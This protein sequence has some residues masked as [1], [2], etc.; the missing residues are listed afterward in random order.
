MK[1]HTFLIALFAFVISLSA[2]SSQKWLAVDASVDTEQLLREKFPKLYSK[3]NAKE[4]VIDK[5]EQQLDKNGEMKYRVT[6]SHKDDDDDFNLLWQT[7][8][9]PMLLGD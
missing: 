8:Y 4:I 7:I 9:M 6:Y 5:V 1:K 2:C 3:V